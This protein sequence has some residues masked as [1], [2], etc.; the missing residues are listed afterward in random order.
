MPQ[1]LT[2]EYVEKNMNRARVNGIHETLQQ[3][4]AIVNLDRSKQTDMFSWPSQFHPR[5]GDHVTVLAGE[6]FPERTGF[7]AWLNAFQRNGKSS[8]LENAPIS[9]SERVAWRE[10]VE[11][12]KALA[13]VRQDNETLRARIEQLEHVEQQVRANPDIRHSYEIERRTDAFQVRTLW[14]GSD[15]QDI[16]E[17]LLADFHQLGRL[18]WSQRI[19]LAPDE[20]TAQHFNRVGQENASERD[21]YQRFPALVHRDCLFHVGDR[22]IFQHDEPDLGFRDG[23]MGQIVHLR[24]DLRTIVVH[25]DHVREPTGDFVRDAAYVRLHE[26]E[27][28]GLG[29]ATTYD[30]AEKLNVAEALV[31]A[32]HE[33][34]CTETVQQLTAKRIH[35]YCDQLTARQQFSDLLSRQEPAHPTIDRTA[36]PLGS[37]LRER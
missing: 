35:I 14:T 24:K 28:V 10:A 8:G 32:S 1:W 31:L 21:D 30:R 27:H 7:A 11:N 2:A 37:Y 13:E 5:V 17:T 4:E 22:V 20:P 12:E 33:A 23:D 9:P 25:L 15:P 3:A 29:Y 6:L 19:M 34:S 26:Y 36:D 16:R 18:T